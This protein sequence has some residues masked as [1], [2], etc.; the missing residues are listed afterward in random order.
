MRTWT[1]VLQRRMLNLVYQP[2][3]SLNRSI[4]TI[5]VAIGAMMGWL[6]LVL[7]GPVQAVAGETKLTAKVALRSVERC[8]RGLLTL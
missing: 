2:R 7:T 3:L 8:T 1:G 4:T 5:T 6:F